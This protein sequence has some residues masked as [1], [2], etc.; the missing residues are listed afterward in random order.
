MLGTQS[1]YGIDEGSKSRIVAHPATWYCGYGKGES[2]FHGLRNSNFYPCINTT[3]SAINSSFQEQNNGYLLNSVILI[4]PKV[5]M[6]FLPDDFQ[7][8]AKDKLITKTNFVDELEIES[9]VK[10]TDGNNPK[11]EID[12]FITPLLENLPE[13]IKSQKSS[14]LIARI[15]NNLKNRELQVWFNNPKIQQL[16]Q[17]TELSGTKTCDNINPVSLIT[18]VIANISGDKRNLYTS[19]NYNILRDAKKFKITYTQSTP[20]DIESRLI[21]EYH[22]ND[23]FGMVAFQIPANTSDY[24]ITSANQ[25][26][27]PFLRKYYQIETEQLVNKEPLIPSNVKQIINSSKDLSENQSEQ[28]G[29]V[30]DNPDGSKV[31]GIYVD[32]TGDFEVNVEFE[33]SGNSWFNFWKEDKV[34]FLGQVGLNQSVNISGKTI[35]DSNIIQKGIEI[36]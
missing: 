11:K 15:E 28:R 23:S 35:S 4:T 17:S 20:I 36:R 16:W 29:F 8:T 10:Y 34:E 14:E 22:P 32:E 27:L 18:P 2:L 7:F 5:I 9:G 21:R 26:N 3:A 6:D 1:I 24:K 19:H 25:Y 13:I 12:S 31:L 30:Y 33:L